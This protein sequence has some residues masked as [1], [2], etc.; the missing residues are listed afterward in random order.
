MAYASRKMI[1]AKQRYGQM[2]KEAPATTWACEKFNYYLIGR[3]FEIETDHKPLVP[4]LG[5]K[6][7]SGLPLRVQRFKMRLMR[8]DYRIFHTPGVE[9]FLADMLSSPPDPK[10]LLKIGRVER[11]I[12]LAEDDEGG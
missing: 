6:D 5:Q 7:L 3:H 8:Y 12:I 4:L 10:E 9:M 1:E 11:Q 2:V